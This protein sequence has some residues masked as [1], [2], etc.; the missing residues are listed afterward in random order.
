MQQ[1]PKKHL[2]FTY[3]TLKKGY[4][5]HRLL[6]QAEFVGK[7][8]TAPNYKIFCNGSFPY[9]IEVGNGEG[10]AVEGEVYKVS[11]AELARCDR[12]ESHP[13][14]YKRT[15]IHIMY[16]LKG[17]S[18]IETKVEGIEAYIYQHK[19]SGCRPCNTNWPQDREVEK[20]V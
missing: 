11:D 12:L 2:I 14:M 20:A 8:A 7:F 10:A 4:H 15:K 17:D 18:L 19:V 16:E 1:E 9:M 5:N 13:D 6:T 3:G